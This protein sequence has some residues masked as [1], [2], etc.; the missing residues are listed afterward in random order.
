MVAHLSSVWV[1]ARSNLSKGPTSAHAC[2]EVTSCM[3]AAK[4][5]AHVAPVVDLGE[6][7]LHSPLQK[8]K[9]IM[10]NPLWL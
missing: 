1:I 6:Y 7:T 3:P 2:G 4:R 8:K 10:Q 5:S 9:Q